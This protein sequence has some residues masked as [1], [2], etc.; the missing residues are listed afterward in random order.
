M[1]AMRAIIA[2][3]MENNP[4]FIN[5]NE[6]RKGKGL[7][8]FLL[9][10]I[11]LLILIIFFFILWFVF[12]DKNNSTRILPSEQNDFKQLLLSEKGEVIDES[13]VYIH[14][15]IEYFSCLAWKDSDENSCLKIL[16]LSEELSS[17]ISGGNM[18]LEHSYASCI[19]KLY[20]NLAVIEENLSYCEKSFYPEDCALK[21]AFFQEMKGKSK[22]EIINRINEQ[23]TGIKVF[24]ALAFVF[25]DPSYCKDPLFCEDKDYIYGCYHAKESCIIF[26]STQEEIDCNSYLS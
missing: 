13:V 5:T 3:K 22:E 12:E 9:S 6:E 10:L 25:R 16:N 21:Y 20:S 18:S 24:E 2:G 17:I 14:P 8:I 15:K 19:D 7:K 4:D 11:L 26:S 23:F 1:G